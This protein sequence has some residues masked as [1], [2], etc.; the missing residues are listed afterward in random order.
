MYRNNAGYGRTFRR[1]CCGQVI[2]SGVDQINHFGVCPLCANNIPIHPSTYATIAWYV[3][4]IQMREYKSDQK[5]QFAI[6]L[7]WGIM[8]KC[9]ELTTIWWCSKALSTAKTYMYVHLSV[10]VQIAV[11]A[12]SVLC[13][14]TYL[15]IYFIIYN[16]RIIS[17]FQLEEGI[18]PNVIF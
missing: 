8:G 3:R 6:I 17:F 5:V 7:H 4:V 1:R 9:G 10:M 15:M 14:R 12:V 11:F 18:V 2:R 16:G 13:L